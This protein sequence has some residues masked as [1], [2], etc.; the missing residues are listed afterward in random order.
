MKQKTVQSIVW[1]A[2]IIGLAV[3]VVALVIVASAWSG[4]SVSGA[5]V[6]TT[7]TAVMI[8]TL[9]L[10]ATFVIAQV[11]PNGRA[12]VPVRMFGPDAWE[13]VIVSTAIPGVL[14][15]EL[16][17]LAIPSMRLIMPGFTTPLFTCLLFLVGRVMQRRRMAAIRG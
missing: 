16:A 2:S 17:E 6:K 7:A 4:L 11:F 1:A 5:F 8:A 14:W 15:H 9:A 13:F 10:Q 12:M 3:D